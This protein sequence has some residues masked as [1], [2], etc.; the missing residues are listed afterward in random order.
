MINRFQ[1]WLL[2]KPK[3][4]RLLIY[5]GLYFIYWFLMCILF[6]LIFFKEEH[7]IVYYTFYGLWMSICWLAFNQ[8]NLI[9]SVFSKEDKK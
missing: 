9:K 7:A 2:N 8:W 5:F 3:K 1:E 6:D 4:A